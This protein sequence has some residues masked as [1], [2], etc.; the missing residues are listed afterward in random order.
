MTDYIYTLSD[1]RNNKVRYVGK[2]DNPKRRLAAHI[3]DKDV[4][5]RTN[6]IKQLTKNNLEPI[7][8]IIEKVAKNQSWE[9]RER[10]WISHYRSIG[11]NLTNMTDGGD[12]GPDC[13][14]KNLVKSEQGRNNIIKALVKRNKSQKMRE[15]SRRN[16]K[17]R[18]GKK[19]PTETVEKIRQKA[20]GRKMHSDEFKE[21]LSNRN[22]ER[23]YDKE[24]MRQNARKLWDDPIKGPIARAKLIERNK[25]RKNHNTEDL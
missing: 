4:C 18:K 16:G 10:Y 13:T 7:M 12:C 25:S 15:I 19:L 2:T 17:R 5:H 24:T 9:D 3:I 8:T 20:I 11:C 6:W 23:E 14:G 21:A 22:K 1:P